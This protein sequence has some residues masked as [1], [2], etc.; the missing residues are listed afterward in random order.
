[1]QHWREDTKTPGA[2]GRILDS[3]TS[4]PTSSRSTTITSCRHANLINLPWTVHRASSTVS[5]ESRIRC[6]SG[7]DTGPEARHVSNAAVHAA[8]RGSSVER[9]PPQLW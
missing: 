3:C 9:D 4:R 7:V 5:L 1:M 6:R 2:V 8:Q